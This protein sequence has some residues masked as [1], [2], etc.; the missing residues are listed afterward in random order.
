[1]GKTS[2]RNGL[3]PSLSCHWLPPVVVVGVEFEAKHA[4]R[5]KKGQLPSVLSCLNAAWFIKGWAN[6]IG[7]LPK[8]D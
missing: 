3:Q 8:E 5:K 2:D 7:G 1:M 6:T 4:R